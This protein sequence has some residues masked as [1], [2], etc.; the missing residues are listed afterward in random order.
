MR[1]KVARRSALVLLAIVVAVSC[2][3]EADLGTAPPGTSLESPPLATDLP[4]S[5]TPAQDGDCEELAGPVALA[6]IDI[7]DGSV[8]WDRTVGDARGAALAG[9]VIAGVGD[10][11]RAVGV[12][13]TGGALLWCLAV[14]RA[15]TDLGN[16]VWP[17][18]A[19]AGG[20]LATATA[21]GHVIGIDPPTGEE[22][23]RV[24]IGMIEG[25]YVESDGERFVLH[26]AEAAQEEPRRAFDPVTGAAVELP[27]PVETSERVDAVSVG[28]V[29]V[30][31][32]TVTGDDGTERWSAQLPG[33][34]MSTDLHDDV[35]V[36]IDQT[37]GVLGG[38][39]DGDDTFVSAY[40]AATG[41]LRWATAAPWAGFS[42]TAIGDLIVTSGGQ[43]LI[44]LDRA[45]GEIVWDANVRD[46]GRGGRYSEPGGVVFVGRP[47]S[48]DGHLVVAVEAQE[49]Y[50]D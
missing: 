49:P 7:A 40:D 33:M 32:V 12:D 19:S 13:A 16:A 43:G 24:E 6:G 27:L 29:Q 4:D 25:A 44:A 26:D 35:V 20:V 3:E 5:S 45:T 10:S 28:Q 36:V 21:D 47:E 23:W 50:R 41:E 17:G 18:F 39:I 9:D 48:T 42:T 2:G 34:A 15:R 30:I 37:G 38:P 14:G 8:R 11:G 31:E 46:L 22:L 1:S